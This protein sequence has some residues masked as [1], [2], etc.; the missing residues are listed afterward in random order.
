MHQLCRAE[1]IILNHGRARGLRAIDVDTGEGL[2]F[3]I[4]EDKALDIANLSF[5]GVNMA[6]LSK[7]GIVNPDVLVPKDNEFLR[8][9]QGGFLYTCGLSNAGAPVTQDGRYH[10]FHGRI[11]NTPAENV[12][13]NEYWQND[14]YFI[15]VNGTL[16]EASLFGENIVQKR[17]IVTKMGSCSLQIH[18]TI[19]NQGFS[20]EQIMIMYHMNIGY[21]MLDKSTRLYLP[22][23]K[24][25]NRDRS[26]LKGEVNWHTF[27][28]PL[29]NREEEV[30][31]HKL[32]GRNDGMTCAALYNDHYGFGIIIEYDIKELPCFTQW[33]SMRSGDYALGLEPGNC[34]PDGRI[35]SLEQGESEI[36]KPGD[37]ISKSICITFYIDKYTFAADLQEYGISFKTSFA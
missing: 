13:L 17:S 28:A 10:P 3:R 18:D 15:E 16:R 14:E 27:D 23:S 24:T 20:D 21:P 26:S 5:Q 6:F 33:K 4:L 34:H 29:P 31:Y 37:K 22:V 19:E 25:L 32:N 1:R 11:G 12:C 2:F 7:P 30:Y 8:V 35:G 9:F 36:L